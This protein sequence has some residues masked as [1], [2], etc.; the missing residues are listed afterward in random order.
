MSILKTEILTREATPEE[1][2]AI[3]EGL[4]SGMASEEETKQILTEIGFYN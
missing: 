1:A 3:Q 2:K 4:D